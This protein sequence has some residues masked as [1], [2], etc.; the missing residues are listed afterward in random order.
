LVVA[1]RPQLPSA[2]LL[3]PA[4]R[5]ALPSPS[6]PVAAAPLS[7]SR[8]QLEVLHSGQWGSVCSD[9]GSFDALDAY[10]ACRSLGYRSGTKAGPSM[11]GSFESAA[12][13]T[14]IW[15]SGLACNGSETEIGACQMGPL[16]NHTAAN[17]V[18]SHR[19]D[20]SVRCV[21]PPGACG[22]GAGAGEGG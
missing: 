17:S 8:A 19:Q 14:P 3:L 12:S 2:C 20:A 10:V 7:L 1:A 13:H 11:T 21:V 4:P 15:V 5:T 9:Q 22:G 6:G 18:C 16:R